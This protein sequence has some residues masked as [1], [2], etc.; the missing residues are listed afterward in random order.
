MLAILRFGA[1]AALGLI[2]ASGC[3]TSSGSE[4]APTP[5]QRNGVFRFSERVPDT[6]PNTII[7]EGRVTVTADTVDFDMVPGPCRYAQPSQQS[8]TA[9]IYHCGDVNVSIDRVDPSR[10]NY[11]LQTRIQTMVTK[12]A[13]YAVVNRVNTCVRTERVPEE[14]QVRR[15]GRLRLIR[16]S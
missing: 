3:S 1:P 11:S 6:S 4:T 13:E 10:I 8:R 14:E 2:M 12:C 9:F 7:L 15:S 16:V 5:A